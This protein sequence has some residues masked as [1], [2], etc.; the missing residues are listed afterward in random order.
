MYCSEFNDIINNMNN[1]DDFCCELSKIKINKTK[2]DFF[3]W[4][5]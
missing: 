1:F 2:G 3:E 5:V 4:F